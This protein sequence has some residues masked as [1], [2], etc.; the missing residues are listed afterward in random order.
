MKVQRRILLQHDAIPR[1]KPFL[2][3]H[4]RIEFL[5]ASRNV[6][7]EPLQDGLRGTNFDRVLY[8]NDVFTT[9]ESVVE[10]LTTRQ[11]DYDMVC[12]LDF[13]HWG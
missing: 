5:A 8:S 7:L 2:T 6:P 13:A 3:N 12:G 9:A 10:L 11:G 1:P 4:P